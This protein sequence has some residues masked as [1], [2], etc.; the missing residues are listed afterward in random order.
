MLPRRYHQSSRLDRAPG[1]TARRL[2]NHPLPSPQL[3]RRLRPKIHH[4]LLPILHIVPHNNQVHTRLAVASTLHA[5]RPPAPALA[6]NGALHRHAELN[7]PHRAV[8]AAVAAHAARARAQLEPAQHARIPLLKHLGVRDAR[9]RHVRVHAALACPRRPRARAAGNRLVVPEPVLVLARHGVLAARAEGEVVAAALAGRGRAERL[10]DH[11]GDTLRGEHVAADDGEPRARVEDAAV[12]DDDVD[13]REAALVERDLRRDEPAQ[14]VDDSGVGDCDRGVGVAEDLR[15]GAGEVEGRGAVGGDGDLERD[16]GAVVHVVDGEE[17]LGAELGEGGL[18]ELAHG[19][20]GRVL[21]CVHVAVDG[22]EAVFG[23]EGLD[24]GDALGVGG[25]LGLEIR[26]VVLQSAGAGAAVVLG[27]LLEQQATDFVFVEAALTDQLRRLD[28]GALLPESGRRRRHGAGEDATDIRVVAARGDVESNLLAVENGRDDGDVGQMRSSARRVVGNEDVTVLQLAVPQVVLVAHGELHRAEMHRDVGSVGDEAT[29]GAEDGTRKV[30]TLLDVGG[31]GRLLQGATHLFGNGHEAMTEDGQLNRAELLLLAVGLGDDLLGRAVDDN[32]AIEYSSSRRRRNENGLRIVDNQ[33]RA[34]D[35]GANRDGLQLIDRS[36]EVAM[37]L[38]V[39]LILAAGS[40][41]SRGRARDGLHLRKG[42]LLNLGASGARRADADVVNDDVLLGEVEP[43]AATVR[44]LKFRLEVP[45]GALEDHQGAARAGVS[46]VEVGV[47]GDAV[48]GEALLHELKGGLGGEVLK[49]LLNACGG[50][51]RVGDGGGALDL[52]HNVGQGHADGGVLVDD[53]TGDAQDSRDGARMLATRTAEASKVVNTSLVTA[54]FSEGTDRAGHALVGNL[55]E[56]QSNLLGGEKRQ[57]RGL[58]VLVDLAGEVEELGGCDFAVQGLVLLG[59]EDLGEVLGQ[60]PAEEQVGVRHGER[61]ALTVAGRAGVS[62]SGLGPDV[63]E[64][65]LPRQ[66]RT[67][68]GS[69]SVNIELRRLNGNAGGRRLEHMVVDTSVPRN[70]G[71][72]TTHIESNHRTALLI[73]PGGLRVADDTTG[74]TGQDGLQTAELAVVHEAAVRLHELDAGSSRREPALEVGRDGVD[75][76]ANDGGEVGVGHGGHAAGHDVDHGLD[77]RRQRHG[78]AHLGRDAAHQ[79]LM[80]R[81]RVRVDEDD[82]DGPEA[83][84]ADLLQ[85]RLD[86]GQVWPLQ[87]PDGLA[88]D[89]GHQLL[90]V[91]CGGGLDGGRV[92]GVV[93]HGNALVDLDDFVKE[94]LWPRHR[95]IEDVGSGLVSDG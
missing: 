20:L 1:T 85:L 86:L 34:G 19:V 31:H 47:V 87:D 42:T 57:A 62:R 93:L 82:G 18:H 14:A 72:G 2:D 12:R 58:A 90:V 51:V 25:D 41:G 54:G 50:L 39:D 13:R 4:S 73:V 76:L 43:E 56:T 33:S 95:E 7:L 28:G 15:A 55:Q 61:A 40:R 91:G 89:G 53:D 49:L 84:L 88:G 44:V 68:S 59:A 78:E 26:E 75:V 16:G 17:G 45:V 3:R 63:E 83:L 66:N 5:I 23:D 37:A 8:A 71:G 79:Q 64:T 52:V 48:L 21:D 69:H 29:V 10:E 11:V 74:R 36:V 60:K 6:E 65:I 92:L 30:E 67:T 77:L 80:V 70:I 94:D 32:V 35:A 81:V 38:K 46:H 27:G 9:V 24:Q 22:G